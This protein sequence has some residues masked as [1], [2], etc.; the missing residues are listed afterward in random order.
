MHNQRLPSS[1]DW[2]CNQPFS[3]CGQQ[4][5]PKL[6]E[7]ASLNGPRDL[8]VSNVLTTFFAGWEKTFRLESVADFLDSF[9]P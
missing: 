3:S 9:H 5:G 8:G 6:C 2:R 7:K 4:I 1:F